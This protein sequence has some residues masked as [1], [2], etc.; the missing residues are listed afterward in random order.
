MDRGK[1]LVLEG[2]DGIGKTTQAEMLNERLNREGIKSEYLHEPGGTDLGLEIERIT[3][4]KE[5][6]RTAMSDLLLF[7]ASRIESYKNIIEPTINEG[8][9]IVADRNWLSTVAYQGHADELGKTVV[10]DMTKAVLP[11][12]Y[13]YPD[14]TFLVHASEEHR[15][16]LLNARG[17]SSKDFFETKPDDFQAKII[18]GY[19]QLDS[20]YVKF[21]HKV[22]RHSVQSAIH[23]SIEGDID[24][25]HER[26][27]QVTQDKIL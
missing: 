5:I 8:G 12:D 11:D 25:A 16:K 18:E 10:R 15:A 1:Y 27:W 9:W 24:E 6:G 22:G 19:S 4:S 21:S 20:T 17:T 23:L 3:K 7:T 14:F 2:S 13:V 26:I